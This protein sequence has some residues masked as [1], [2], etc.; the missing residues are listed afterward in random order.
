ML[1]RSR[2][3]RRSTSPSQ[4]RTGRPRP[5]PGRCRRSRPSSR[6]VFS[7][8]RCRRA[9]TGRRQSRRRRR[10]A[11][12][13]LD[14]ARHHR[15]RAEQQEALEHH[16]GDQPSRPRSAPAGGSAGEVADERPRAAAPALARGAAS[17]PGAAPQQGGAAITKAAAIGP[18]ANRQPTRSARMPPPIWPPVIPSI[19]PTR[20]RA[21]TGWRSPNGTLSPIQASD[22]GIAAP[23][24]APVGDS[25]RHQ[26]VQVRRQRA[27]DGAGAGQRRR[28]GDDEQLAVAVAQ[29]AEQELAAAVGEREA[30]GG[31]RHPASAAPRTGREQRQQRIADPHRGGAGEG[32]ERQ[33]EDDAAA[34]SGGGRR[35]GHRRGPPRAA[36]ARWAGGGDWATVEHTKRPGPIALAPA[37][38]RGAAAAAGYAGGW[39]DLP[40]SA[41]RPRWARPLRRGRLKGAHA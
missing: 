40:T 20:Y 16:G 24:N 4:P 39:P 14:V 25:R 41:A 17:T 28:D 34:V 10:D 38:G 32:A 15:H 1:P 6:R 7:H 26:R 22:S 9:R 8:R 29:R 33:Q 36:A 35:R 11:E 30:G 2:L 12:V 37:G 18:K 19:W 27:G 3:R 31:L 5:S 21:S 13:G 23:A